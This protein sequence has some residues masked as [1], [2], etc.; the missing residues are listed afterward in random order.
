MN[1][2]FTS[3]ISAFKAAG[4]EIVTGNMIPPDFATFWSQAAQQGFKPKIVT[5]GKALLFPSAVE[6]LGARGDGLSTEIWWTPNHPFKSGL[7]GQSCQALAD[8]YTKAT[9]RPWTQ[10]IG[11]QHAMF[12]VAIDILKR[13]KSIE[14][15]PILDAMVATNYQ[16]IVGPVQWTGKPVKNVTKTPLVAGQWKKKGDKSELVIVANRPAPNIPTGGKLELL[17]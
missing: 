8:A 1:N 4:C 5:I 12:E 10:P 11:F 15:K 3:Q 16:S 6:S 2:D 17:S 13:A 14:P 7:T 9:K